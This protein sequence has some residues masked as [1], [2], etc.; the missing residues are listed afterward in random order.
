M[1]RVLLLL[2][3]AILCTSCLMMAASA[4]VA[5][6]EMGLEA[7]A[8]WNIGTND[9]G[10]TNDEEGNLLCVVSG[11]NPILMTRFDNNPLSTENRYLVLELKNETTNTNISFFYQTTEHALD[12]RER[13]DIPITANDT[14]FKK[15]VVDLGDDEFWTGGM[16]IIRLDLNHPGGTEIYTGNVYFSSIRLTNDPD[17]AATGPAPTEPTEPAGPTE[18]TVPPVTVE[19]EQSSFN[20]TQDLQGWNPTNINAAITEEGVVCDILSNDPMLT[21]GEMNI[22]AA[23]R[24]LKV[25]L[26]NESATDTMQVY[27]AVGFADNIIA[28]NSVLFNVEA[29]SSEF[30]EY[31]IDLGRHGSWA[32]LKR[33][34]FDLNIF[35][36]TS[37]KVTISDLELTDVAPEGFDSNKVI[38]D[39]T[40]GIAGFTNVN[41]VQYLTADGATKYTLGGLDPFICSSYGLGI[42]TEYKFLRITMRSDCDTKNMQVYFATDEHGEINEEN[43]CFF[44]VEKTDDFVTYVIDLSQSD[45]YTGTVT[46][47]RFDLT[48]NSVETGDVYIQ[49]IEFAKESEPGHE[50]E[51][52]DSTGN[53]GGIAYPPTV[54]GDKEFKL[55][56]G[57][58]KTVTVT[59]NTFGKDMLSVSMGDK[60]LGTDDY[61]YADGTL[62]LTADFVESLTAKAGTYKLT[63]TT[64]SGSADF[65]VTV[66]GAAEEDAGS[67]L[68]LIIVI[69]AVVIVAGVVAFVVIKK[70]KK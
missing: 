8:V 43:A 12:G 38:L 57:D 20:F 49:S 35:N 24:Y 44:A 34:R 53:G 1:K 41:Q 55:N 22:P 45:N 46:Q 47:L 36:T 70:R 58:K 11:K 39:F 64:E 56:V 66:L 31:V 51:G 7:G 62:M 30:K 59:F 9:L 69:A 3:A 17:A 65:T 4:E 18:P 2:L 13:V 54:T 15:Y 23:K 42:S 60:V 63:F 14:E 32:D 29:N 40:N 6:Y 52:G 48:D 16:T 68:V 27:F 61:M 28:E 5:P 67:P 21:S 10:L 37:G 50:V 26:K 33:I 25:R 19:P